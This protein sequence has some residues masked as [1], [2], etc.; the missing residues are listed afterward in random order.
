MKHFLEDRIFYHITSRDNLD[1]IFSHGLIPNFG[2][3]TLKCDHEALIYMTTKECLTSWYY[4]LIN[5]KHPINNPVILRIDCT[6]LKLMYRNKYKNGIE[7]ASRIKIDSQK[8][9]LIEYGQISRILESK[10]FR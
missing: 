5:A 9:K 10:R 2:P 8:I 6:G 7:V 4:T 3:R 1:S